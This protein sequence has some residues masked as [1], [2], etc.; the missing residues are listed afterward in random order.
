[1]EL[2]LSESGMRKRAQKQ[3]RLQKRLTYMRSDGALLD[4]GDDAHGIWRNHRN[5]LPRSRA[6]SYML[7]LKDFKRVCGFTPYTWLAISACTIWPSRMS[8]TSLEAKFGV[9]VLC[10]KHEKSKYGLD[11]PENLTIYTS[12]SCLT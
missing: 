4:D 1:M 2:E 8:K 9:V 12:S 10:G 3:T 5:W 7:E 11:P 6:I